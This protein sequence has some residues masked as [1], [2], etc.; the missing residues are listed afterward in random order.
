VS[1]PD[2][3]EYSA[4][5][6]LRLG[7]PL[8][9]QGDGLTEA[10][11]DAPG[12]PADAARAREWW[13]ARGLRDTEPPPV[14]VSPVS[15]RADKRWPPERFAWLCDWLTER[16]GRRLL[17][18]YG[19]GEEAQVEAVIARARSSEAF[20]HPAPVLSFSSLPAALVRCGGY[21][22]NDNAIRHLAIACSLPTL[23]VFGRPRPANWT[24][25]GSPQHLAAGGG[26]GI[27]TV[28]LDAVE[29]LLPAFEALLQHAVPRRGPPAHV[30]TRDP[31]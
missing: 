10:T 29:P 21:V 13:D 20:I 25:P 18:F 2:S 23:A 27:G 6:K 16:T 14:A 15:R 31:R 28:T 30:A 26:C 5:Q 22:G 12:T 9:V 8:G 3:E 7:V 19:P 11:L 1:C 17:P 4:R 24:P